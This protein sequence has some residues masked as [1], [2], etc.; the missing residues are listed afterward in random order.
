M[1]REEGRMP[2][3]SGL[4]MANT[5]KCKIICSLSTIHLSLVKNKCFTE[6]DKHVKD[7]SKQAFHSFHS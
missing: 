5:N 1:E 2:Y 3:L 7:L 4:F 6:K